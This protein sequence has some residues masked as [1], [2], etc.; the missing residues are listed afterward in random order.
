MFESQFSSWTRYYLFS[1]GT[2]FKAR[3]FDSKQDALN[4]MYK[5]CDKYGIHLEVSEDDVFGVKYTNH[6]GCRF[7]LNKV[8]Y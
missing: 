3:F 5:Y 8:I 6:A 4:A 7:Y 1:T 2:K